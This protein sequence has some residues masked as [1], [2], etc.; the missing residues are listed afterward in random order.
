M[1]TS[2]LSEAVKEAYASNPDGV[3]IIHTLEFRHPNF[4]D[5]ANQP[6]A[7]RVALAHD[8]VS[9]T[10][11]ASAPLNP[12]ETVDFVPMN[13]EFKAPNVEHVA[14]PELEFS[15]DNVSREIEENLSLAAASPSPVEVT[16]RPYL[17]TDL[18]APQWDPPLTLTLVSVEADDFRVVA[19]A[20]YGSAANKTVPNEVYNTARFPGLARG[21]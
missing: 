4:I 13:F 15:M 2:N 10:L 8:T 1:P 9:A 16:Y 18:S 17:S 7:I 3:V 11:E 19:R 21:A 14:E 20:A 6:T 12:T 5:Q